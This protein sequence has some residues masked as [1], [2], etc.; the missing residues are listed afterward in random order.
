MGELANWSDKTKHVNIA[1]SY[2]H[3]L[4][5][6]KR[7]KL[8]HV[9]SGSNI[10]DI[11]TKPLARVAFERL[12][13]I[14]MGIHEDTIAVSSRKNGSHNYGRNAPSPRKCSDRKYCPSTEY[15]RRCRQA[16]PAKKTQSL[17]SD[18]GEK[19]L[20]PGLPLALREEC[21]CV[22]TDDPDKATETS[23]CTV[24]DGIPLETEFQRSSERTLLR[25]VSSG[26]TKSPK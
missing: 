7:M 6:K 8:F 23:K 18:G 13:D 4:I 20:S 16:S 24:A 17:R 9:P 3:E 1:E 10:S 26:R 5:R 11:M 21:F 25:S 2:L 12:R 14:L 19:S 22:A 15:R